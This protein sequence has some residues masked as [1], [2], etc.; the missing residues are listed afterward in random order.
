[1]SGRFWLG[2][3]YQ[4]NPPN[5]L[6]GLSVVWIKGQRECCPTTGRE[7]WQ[8]IAGFKRQVRLRTVKREVGEGHWEVT[9]SVAADDYVWKED[10]R[11]AGT[12]FEL[13]AKPFRRNNATDWDTIKASA[14]SGELE[15]IPSDVFVRYYSSLCR[16]VLAKVEEPG[17]KPA[18]ALML[19]ILDRSGGVDTG[20]RNLLCLMNFEVGLTF[21]MYCDGSI[22]TRSVWRLKEVVDRYWPHEYGSHRTLTPE[23]GTQN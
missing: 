11:V 7:H 19:K 8:I 1:M 14:M 9:R 3:L 21:R 16:R 22:V 23:V 15:H 20:V 12:Q 2:T 10:T 13:G 6:P 17:M 4:W 18:W 5:E